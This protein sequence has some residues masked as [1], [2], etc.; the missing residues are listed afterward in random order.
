MLCVLCKLSL[1]STCGILS[2]VSVQCTRSILSILCDIHFMSQ[3]AVFMVMEINILT[4]CYLLLLNLVVLEHTRFPD[5][6]NAHI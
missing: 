3:D 5:G 4:T 1:G 2:S 6:N